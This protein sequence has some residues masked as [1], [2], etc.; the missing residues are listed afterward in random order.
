[1]ACDCFDVTEDDFLVE[2]RRLQRTKIRHPGK[3]LVHEETV[4]NCI[5]HNFTGLGICI[6]L[7]FTAEHLPEHVD[8]SFDNFR[9]I[10]SCR[11]IWREGSVV[12]VACESLAKQQQLSDTR[13]AASLK[14]APAHEKRAGIR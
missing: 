13:R 3:V 6:E 9:T 5:V 14:F 7:G 4:H 1:V 12:G 10:H 8:F 11:I 2:R